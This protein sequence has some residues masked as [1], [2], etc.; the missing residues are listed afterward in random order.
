MVAPVLCIRLKFH[1][2]RITC[3]PHGSVTQG[4]DRCT[5]SRT[6]DHGAVLLAVAPRLTR[7]TLNDFEGISPSAVSKL[8]QLLQHLR[9]LKHLSLDGP[10]EF[11]NALVFMVR[12]AH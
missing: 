10:P 12:L 2:I 3:K 11:T 5:L 9:H 4:R 7:L 8:V 1:T 6:L